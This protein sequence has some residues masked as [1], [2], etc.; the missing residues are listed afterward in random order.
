MGRDK[1]AVTLGGRPLIAW[2]IER[3]SPQVAALAISRHDGRLAGVDRGLPVLTDGPG[4]QA[5]PVAGVLAGLD[6]AADLDPPPT[7]VVTV[8]VD[9]P[10]LPLDLVERLAAVRAEARTAAAV[11]ASGGRRHP[12]AALWPVA[13]R[14]ALREAL[15]G[16]GGR[17]VGDVLD[18]LGAAVAEWPILPFDPFLNLNAPEDLAAAESYVD[19]ARAGARARGGGVPPA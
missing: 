5:G 19:C 16:D 4:G 12:V 11:A 18:Q 6:W 3:L 2:A 1:A 15:R 7:H 9:T 10:F 13:A 17:R 8:A 14:A